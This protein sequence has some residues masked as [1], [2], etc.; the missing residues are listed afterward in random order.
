M[1]LNLKNGNCL[2]LMKELPDKSV[3]LFICDLP[4]GETNCKF[5]FVLLNSDTLLLNLGRKDLRWIWSGKKETRQVDYNQD[6]DR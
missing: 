1:T 2:E 6:T 3:D 4:Y 5:I